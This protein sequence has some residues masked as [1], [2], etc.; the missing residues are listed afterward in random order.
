VKLVVGLG[1][2]GRRYAS[3]RHNVGFRVAE[4]F[5]RSHGIPL[6]PDRC[7]GRFGRGTARGA[8]AASADV[9]V[10][11]PER[12]MNRSGAVLA[13]ALSAHPVEDPSEDVIVVFDDVDLPFG[14]LRVRPSGRSAGHRGLENVIE[15][16]GSQQFP[17]LRFGIG[18]PA[19]DVETT[20]YV[21][22]D[23]SE[24]ESVALDDCMGNAVAALDTIL[25]EGLVPAMNAFNRQESADR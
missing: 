19:G 5:A 11:L 7:G 22:A 13:E 15:C 1:N 6:S 8:G 21:L 16:L 24:A 12:Y 17:R 2:P 18:H 14:R 20:D 25:F 9:G 23:F 10:L 3:T 4:R